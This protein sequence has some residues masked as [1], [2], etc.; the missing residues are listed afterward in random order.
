MRSAVIAASIT[1]VFSW[2]AKAQPMALK[3]LLNNSDKVAT[4][5]TDNEN[6]NLISFYVHKVNPLIVAQMRNNQQEHFYSLTIE[7]NKNLVTLSS[8]KEIVALDFDLYFKS[9]DN[10]FSVDFST[11]TVRNPDVKNFTSTL[12]FENGTSIEITCTRN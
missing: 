2:V 11:E 12:L 10:K 4:C 7:E 1:L 5:K 8:D 3:N 9:T 6:L